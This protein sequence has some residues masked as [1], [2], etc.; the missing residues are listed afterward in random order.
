MRNEVIDLRSDT[1]TLPTKE[2][3]DAIALAKLGDDIQGDDPTVKEL[4]QIAASILGMEDALLVLSGTMANQIAV[5]VL[6]NRGEEI[7]VGEDSH[8]FNLEVAGLAVLSQVQARPLAVKDGHYS[9]EK[10]ESM[11]QQ[12]DIQRASTSLICLENTY[13][14]NQGQVLS[15]ENMKEIKNLGEQYFIPIYL[16]GARLFNASVALNVTPADIC[17]YTD[18][19]QFCLTKGLGCPLGSILAGDKA[20]IKEARRMRQRLGGGMRQAGIIAAPAIYA[21]EHLIDRLQNDHD[22]AAYL[23]NRLSTLEGIKLNMDD[24]QTNI[25]SFTITNTNWSADRLI[26]YLKEKN[27]LVKKIGE[28]EIRM[29][30]HY[31]LSTKAIDKVIK[32]F[33][34][35]FQ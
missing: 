28:K 8:L 32:Q 29:V 23:A 4:E 25:A 2:M 18:A 24:V 20:F 31:D 22:K 11:I 27:I 15:L 35:I 33:N 12:G 3:M 9:T 17:Q 13:N 5:M 26:T 21:L 30:T 19:V 10:I 7:I 14:L 6:T 16:D 34:A 1:V